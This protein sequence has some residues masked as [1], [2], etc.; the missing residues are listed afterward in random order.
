MIQ[1]PWKLPRVEAPQKY[2]IEANSYS[3]MEAACAYKNLGL[4]PGTFSFPHQ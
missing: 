4:P 1:E 2:T 3:L